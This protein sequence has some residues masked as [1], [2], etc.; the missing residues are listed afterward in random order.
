MTTRVSTHDYECTYYS[1]CTYIRDKQTGAYIHPHIHARW[2]KGKGQK[3]A[4][5]L[6]CS[7]RASARVHSILFNIY[8]DNFKI[9]LTCLKQ[10]FKRLIDYA[11]RNKRNQ[12]VAKRASEPVLRV[13]PSLLPFRFNWF[14]TQHSFMKTVLV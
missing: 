14:P 6:G 9:Q 8:S 3:R 12:R 5:L 13:H 11:P 2:T 1:T 4:C 7:P 10:Y